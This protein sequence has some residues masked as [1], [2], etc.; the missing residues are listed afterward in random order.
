MFLPEQVIFF[1]FNHV[2]HAFQQTP[3]G[4][5]SDAL[6]KVSPEPLGPHL[7]TGDHEQ[8]EHQTQA[9]CSHWNS[10]CRKDPTKT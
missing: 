3:D 2:N 9:K 7:R 8:E 6:C 10:G 5:I 4:S 1:S